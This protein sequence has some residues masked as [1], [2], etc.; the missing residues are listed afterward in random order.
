MITLKTVSYLEKIMPYSEPKEIESRNVVFKNGKLH[1]QIAMH[2]DT[3][4]LNWCNTLRIDGDL[5]D[6]VT[7]RTVELIAGTNVPHEYDDYYLSHDV[8]VF[9]DLLKPLDNLGISIPG[10]GW[11]SVW[12]TVDNLENVNAGIY[13]L[14]FTLI[15]CEGV[16]HGSI[17]YE[18]EVLD[19][20][21]PELTL[22]V[23][24]WMHYDCIS[25]KHNVELFTDGFYDIFDKYLSKYTEFGNTMLLVPLFTPPLDTAVGFERQTAQLIDITVKGDEYEFNFEPL[26]RFIDFILARGVKYL[27]F[28][29]LFTQWGGK[30]CPKIVA[31]VNGKVERIF[32]WKDDSDGERYTAF[33]TAFLPK[34][35]E[36]INEWGIK[37]ISYFHLTDEPNINNIE[38]YTYCRNIVKKFIGDIP[39]MDALSDYEFYKKGLVDIPVSCINH[40]QD[41]ADNNVENVFAYY[42]CNPT[43]QYYCNR[44]LN[45]PLQRARVCGFALYQTNAKGFLHWGFN[46]YNTNLSLE[47][48]NPYEDSS[49]AGSYPAGDGYIVYPTKDDLL[50]S[51]RAYAIADGFNDY[52]LCKKCESIIGRE[53]TK[54]ILSSY[55]F[56]SYNV[57]PRS[58]SAHEEARKALIN[59][60]LNNK[61]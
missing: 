14:T 37:D 44:F 36:K 59:V 20:V 33:L 55:G 32:G 61:K 41:F 16:E 19:E 51:N 43:N 5:K 42:C 12:I 28:S 3:P 22:P 17:T 47:K 39:T 15:N 34:L 60:V 58:I 6:N 38:K 10:K 30:F 7:V 50:Y 2:N 9:P 54:K 29:H 31:N 4:W 1:F 57:Y 27:E 53:E 35:V 49:L 48:F 40:Y 52:R 56:E 8:G 11:K 23:T 18:V 24:N 46:Y 13:P 25:E 21:L 26:H 45:M